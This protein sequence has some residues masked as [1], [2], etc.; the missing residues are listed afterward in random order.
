LGR[1]GGAGSCALSLDQGMKKAGALMHS[2]LMFIQELP[3]R[4][5]NVRNQPRR[6]RR[7]RDQW[8][9]LLVLGVGRR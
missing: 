9:L 5:I 2:G 7:G 6:D 1:S 8:T 3:E 4:G